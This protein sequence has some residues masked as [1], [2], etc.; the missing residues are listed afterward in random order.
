[1]KFSLPTRFQ[2]VGVLL[3]LFGLTVVLQMINIQGNANVMSIRDKSNLIYEFNTEKIT[4][5]R[6]AIY[7]RWGHLLAGNK[8]VY[9]VG[10][11]LKV[12]TRLGNGN[13][14]ANV[15]SNVLGL[16]Y[17]DTLDRISIPYDP[18][19]N[20]VYI[21]VADFISPA[22][23]EQLRSIQDE[24]EKLYV[25]EGN[26]SSSSQTLR[27]VSW[28]PHLQRTYPENYLAANILG[29]YSLLDIEK[30]E[31]HLGVEEKYNALLRGT[32]L[33]IASPVD[34]NKIKEYIDV[35]PGS[36]LIL[37]IDRE[38]QAS[39][40]NILDNAVA[41]NGAQSG[42]IIVMDPK[43]G[44]ILAMASNPRMNPNSY[45]EYQDNYFNRPIDITYE[46]GSVFKVLTMAIALDTEAVEPD[47]EFIDTGSINIGGINI[48]NWDRAAWGPQDMVGC[49]QHSLNVC[50]AWVATEVGPDDYYKYLLDFGMGRKTNIDLAGEAS[51]PLNLPG[52]TWVDADL[53]ANSF[54]QGIAVT[55]IQMISAI[56]A[57]A[58]DGKMMAP[59]TL[60]SVI[61]S[62]QRRDSSPM[63]VGKP[64]SEETATTL[65][66]MLATSM[67]REA[68]SALVP[69]YR[70]A[71][72]TGTAEIPSAQGYT[73]EFTNASF[74]GWGPVDDPQFI[75]Y[76]WIEK[77]TSSIWGSVVAAP[78]FQEVVSELVVLMDIPPDDIRHQLNEKVAK[79]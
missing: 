56:S 11:E 38:I 74:V 66:N 52:D 23:I 17:Q 54:G 61:D 25:N 59:H 70:L 2:I 41:T 63:I 21:V 12:V 68:S 32:P 44:E 77:P 36:S 39:V 15:L 47:T 26:S 43:T 16:D 18:A 6:G 29:F 67:E 50:L 35:P 62:G 57:V 48:Y 34:P 30:G 46:P 7:D 53:A 33:E 60:L 78:V 75:V 27:G 14:I 65:S 73:N 45:W 42:S 4:P 71:G 1:M 40:E 79:E 28:N 19:N 10:V 72:K 9:E 5:E 49:M 51:W 24:Y 64:I 8:E 69:G 22:K 76:I 37:T 58:N 3:T 55:P 31:A 20:Q 13:T